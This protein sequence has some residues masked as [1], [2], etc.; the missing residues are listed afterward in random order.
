MSIPLG[1]IDENQG[2]YS[3]GYYHVE[4]DMCKKEGLPEEAFQCS[5]FAGTGYTLML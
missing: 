1:S 2:C 5:R 4:I 3:A